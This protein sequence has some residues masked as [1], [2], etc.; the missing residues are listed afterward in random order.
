MLG[1]FSE[2]FLAALRFWPLVA[3]GLTLPILAIRAALGNRITWPYLLV[4]YLAVLYVLGLGFF[5]LYPMPDDPVT[6]CA[7]NR[8]TA[9]LVP[10]A[11]VGEVLGPMRR[12]MVFQL[13]ANVAFFVPLGSFLW[14]LLRGSLRRAAA[15]GLGTSLLIETAQL[16]GAFGLYPCSFRLFDVDDLM[17]NTLGAVLGFLV[18]RFLSIDVD[19]ARFSAPPAPPTWRNRM[20]AWVIDLLLVMCSVALTLAAGALFGLEPRQG[21]FPVVL[22]CWFFVLLVLVPW[23]RRATPGALLVGLPVRAARPRSRGG[24]RPTTSP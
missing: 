12:Y 3:L 20:L 8:T 5:T 4:A 18:T 19:A 24:T 9:Q 2:S 14:A 17:V 6:Y 23:W 21:V 16:T 11:W 15:V 10:F 13:L 7:T 1:A 22:G